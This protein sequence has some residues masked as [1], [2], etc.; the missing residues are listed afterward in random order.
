MPKSN[1]QIEAAVTPQSGTLRLYVDGTAGDDAAAGTSWG[2]AWKTLARLERSVSDLLF[3]KPT[4]LDLRCFVRGAFSNESIRLSSALSGSTRVHLLHDTDDMTTVASGTVAATGAAGAAHGLASITFNAPMVPDATWL[5]RYLIL[6]NG[7]SRRTY[8]VLRVFGGTVW[9]TAASFPAWVI[10]GVSATVKRPS[11]S[12]IT[13]VAQSWQPADLY[14]TSVWSSRRCVT[15]GVRA[16]QFVWSLSHWTMASVEATDGI[17]PLEVSGGSA[18]AMQVARGFLG[19]LEFPDS[20]MDDVHAQGGADP[21]TLVGCYVP[22]GQSQS[23]GAF[24]GLGL[25]SGYY[26]NLFSSQG[27]AIYLSSAAFNS[28]EALDGVLT[29]YQCIAGRGSGKTYGVRANHGGRVQLNKTSFLDLP[30]TGLTDGLVSLDKGGWCQLSNT[31]DGNN[32]GTAGSG[33]VALKTRKGSTIQVENSPSTSLQGKHGFLF[34]EGGDDATFAAAV[35]R[36]AEAGGPDFDIGPNSRIHFAAAVTK[37]ATNPSG[38]GT[39]APVIRSRGGKVTFAAGATFTLPAGSGNNTTDYGANGAID[40]E[41]LVDAK[42]AALAGGNAAATGT[43]VRVKK[44]SRLAH[45][46]AAPTWGAAALDLGGLPGAVAMPAAVLSDA[47]AVTP[48]DCWVMP[49]TA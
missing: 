35:T 49:G 38:G 25:W 27:G 14:D 45:S 4:A 33:L 8:Q 6:D 26:N 5:G 42:F 48:E 23:D 2:T 17:I 41:G 39:A 34:M 40:L 36:G 7:V 32:T 20:L 43:A 29:T 47:G 21:D 10:N 37:S 1:A 46:G 16:A 24:G 19:G 28:A 31:V 12:G 11:V 15:F 13:M 18:V 3:V 30:A 9:T 44:G 22:N